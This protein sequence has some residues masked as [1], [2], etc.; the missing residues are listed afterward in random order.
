MP[1]SR[2]LKQV[3][4]LYFKRIDMQG[5]KSF[6]DPV[7]IEFNEGIT[8][9][10]GPNGSGKSNISDA[11]RWVLGEQS[12]KMLRG[13]KMEEVIFAGTANRKSRGMAEVTLVIDN[14]TSILPIDYSEVAITRRMFRS[15]E[16]EYEIN[17]RKCRLR[18]IR[19]LIMDTGI[20]V[21]GYS[22]IGQGKIADIVSGKPETRREIFE[23]AAGV[24]MYRTKKAE[25]ERRLETTNANLSRAD[26]IIGEL[27]DR[28]PKLKEDSAKAKEYLSLRERYKEL[29]INITLKNIE[30][31]ELKNEYLKDEISEA[32]VEIDEIKERKVEIDESAAQGRQKSENLEMLAGEARG[33]LLALIEEIN[34][35]TNKSQLESEKL[36]AMEKDEIRLAGEIDELSER[37][38]KEENNAK[39][40]FENKS[41]TDKRAEALRA[42]LAEKLGKYSELSGE[43]SRL[44]M[45]ADEKKNQVFALR[46]KANDKEAE[47]K[48]LAGMRE[49]LERRRSQLL[50]E[51]ENTEGEDA[52]RAGRLAA[53]ENEKSAIENSITRLKKERDELRKKYSEVLSEERELSKSMED[54]RIRVGRL[55]E[56]K[57]T[58][59]EM[60]ANYE[61]YSGAVRF[62]MRSALSGIC[63]VV[64]ELIDVPGG[65]EIAIET[66]LGGALQNVVCE[67]DKS[68]QRAVAALKSAR[69]GRLT[70]LPIS[71]VKSSPVRDSYISSVEGFVGFGS[72][73]VDYDPKYR[74]VVEYLLGRVVVVDNLQNAIKASKRSSGG[75]RFVTLEGE[76]INTGGAITGGAYK[77]KTAN[78]LERKA[79]VEKL[80]NELSS[81]TEA[82]NDAAERLGELRRF[83][84][85]AQETGQNQSEELKSLE[86]SLLSKENEL[87]I[88]REAA[89][90]LDSAR[91]K[92]R[93]EMDSIDAEQSSSAEMIEEMRREIEDFRAQATLAETA[94]ETALSEHERVS[95]LLKQA[96]EEITKARMAANACENEKASADAIAERIE[97]EIA[98]LKNGIER[99]N[100]EIDEIARQRKGLLEGGGISPEELS[101]KQ[102]EKERLDSYLEE[103]TEEKAQLTR[104]ANEAVHEKEELERRLEQCRDAKYQSQA[105]LDRNELQLESYKNKLWEEFEVPYMQALELRNPDISISAAVKENREIKN[106]MKELGD[107]NV[108]AISEYESV[109]DRFKFLADQ[110]A[111][112]VEAADSLKKI[113]DDMDRTIRTRFKESFDAVAGN[114]EAVF[115]ELFG[116]GHAE[117]RLEDENNPLETGIEIIAQPPGKKLQNLNL[118]SGGEKTM[119]AIALMFAVLRSKPTP[120]C[121]LDEVEAALDDANIDRFANYLKNFHDIQFALI[122][123]QKAT[124]EHADVLYGVTM[125]E[126]GISKL[127][128]LRLGSFTEEDYVG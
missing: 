49:A 88:E 35:A 117:L 30:T 123:H 105:K 82:K 98:S 58:I 73:C 127:L 31:V 89:K 102:E 34:I 112:I 10:V 37:L 80:A 107:I 106:R 57:R 60:E 14:S 68:A 64:A 65:Y 121:I 118:M 72:E 25:T 70:F 59:E 21:D 16:S 104:E 62:V 128:S 36:A 17:G 28:I 119:T 9:I 23:E 67:D 54:L 13:G 38:S 116:G 29:E 53:L 110:R 1:R 47:I 41:E 97:T 43:V 66:A 94:G 109:N 45:T 50:S 5:F 84:E 76:I 95:E 51:G 126:R 24:V 86:M 91:E 99:R 101:E 74:P 81:L 69:A 33:K 79:E 120:F 111:D 125:P 77:N 4:D 96:S 124:M 108:G 42:D 85:E 22:I 103:I 75:L 78:L 113:I 7:S 56:R 83:L 40:L 8:C 3:T 87:R 11:L 39:A 12:P 6:A 18:D 27:E 48:S 55:A 2:L 32:S 63:G 90:D 15:G 52:D 19:E 114:F 71:S 44:A 115:Q 100:A 122:T 61:G 92:R 26:D 46:K 93:R 20:G